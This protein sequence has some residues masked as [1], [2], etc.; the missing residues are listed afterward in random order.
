MNMFRKLKEFKYIK[1]G[2]GL[3]QDEMHMGRWFGNIIYINKVSS[4]RE[5][6]PSRTSTNQTFSGKKFPE[7]FY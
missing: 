4:T 5:T 1:S 2:D 7:I 6:L 3:R